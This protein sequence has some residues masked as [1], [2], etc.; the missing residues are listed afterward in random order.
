MEIE[1]LQKITTSVKQNDVLSENE[2]AQREIDEMNQIEIDFKK[3]WSAKVIEWLRNLNYL[4][5]EGLLMT[6]KNQGQYHCIGTKAQ[7]AMCTDGF[8]HNFGLHG[9]MIGQNGRS[10]VYTPFTS[11]GIEM[12]GACGNL[13]IH[14]DGIDFWLSM[15]GH[16][17]DTLRY[18]M[19]YKDY[20]ILASN[21]FNCLV[22]FEKNYLELIEGVK[23]GTLKFMQM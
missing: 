4:A 9:N 10:L 2:K 15:H 19:R 18:G 20:K 7:R 16:E 12:G 1:E 3:Q 21:N 6:S 8:Y 22:E 17:E 13:D 14:T 23:N 11:M 5:K